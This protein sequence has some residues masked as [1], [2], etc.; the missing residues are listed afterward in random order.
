MPAHFNDRCRDKDLML[1][2]TTE[3]TKGFAIGGTADSLMGMTDRKAKAKVGLAFVVSHPSQM[4]RRMG[5]PAVGR[6]IEPE[7]GQPA[8]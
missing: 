1:G 4:R 3:G 6:A 5:H 7:S 2:F 8:V